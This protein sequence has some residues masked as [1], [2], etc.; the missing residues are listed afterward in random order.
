MPEPQQAPIHCPIKSVYDVEPCD[1]DELNPLL[2]H[3]RENTSL[4]DAVSVTFPRGTILSDGRLDLC[5]QSL[6]PGGCRMVTEALT[7]NTRIKSLLL[8]TDGIGDGGANDVAELIER[9]RHIEIVYL[10][11]NRIS[12]AGVARLC[13][14]LADNPTVTGLWL[15]RNPIGPEGARHVA[16]MLR[17][18]R[19]LRTL[20]LVNTSIGGEGLAAVCDA[21]TRDNRTLERLYLG[22]NDIDGAEGAAL[23]ALLLKRNP[24]LK[25]LLLNVNHL[26]DAGAETLA[27]ALRENRTLEELG[28][29][30]CGISA[31]G[32]TAL[33][34]AL[35]THPALTDLD[36]GYSASTRVLGAPANALGDQ[37]AAEAADYLSTNPPLRKLNLR[38]NSIGEVGRDRLA[39]AL[40]NNTNLCDLIL[41]GKQ[42]ARIAAQLARNR[43][44]ANEA[45][46]RPVSDVALI[47][48]VYRT[49]AV[50]R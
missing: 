17:R 36:L 3:L 9:N 11:C 48:S 18:N 39:A 37:G 21:L 30:S 45:K 47:R 8:G 34:G 41:D 32:G 12:A 31:S 28:L 33:F 43:E 25:A 44:A 13:D 15:K 1:P 19:T 40:E 20:D 5:K 22:G 14:T 23:I 42:D 38:C 29:A 35:R 46:R 4:E 16:A 50:A 49:A 27:D 10:G 2:A 26:A 6:G 24:S 7:R